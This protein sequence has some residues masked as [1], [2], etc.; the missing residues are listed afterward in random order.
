MG[1][2]IDRI[3]FRYVVDFIHFYFI[4]DGKEYYWP[5]F[6]VAD[7]AIVAG[8]IWFLYLSLFTN[9]LDPIEEP[10]VARDEAAE[11]AVPEKAA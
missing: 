3:R 4:R 6:N 10:V 11:S 2:L 8:I 7:M 9:Q 5:T 1:N